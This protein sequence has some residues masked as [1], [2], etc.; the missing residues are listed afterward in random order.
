[1]KRIINVLLYGSLIALLLYVYNL[2]FLI[3]RDLRI[4]YLWLS[5][6]ILLLFTGFVFS[7]ISWKVALNLHNVKAGFKEAIYSQGIV[8]FTKYIPGRVW[9]ILGRAAILK[10]E[11]REL[12]RLSFI[13]FKEQLVYLCLGFFISIYPVIRTEKIQEYAWIIFILTTLLFLLLF[14]SSLQRLFEK[15]WNRIFKKPISLPKISIKEFA[16]LS[17]VIII[18]WFFWIAGFY[19]LLI[20]VTG[21]VPFYYAFAF[22]LSVVLGLI[23]IIFPGGIGVREGAITLFLIS[24]GISAD[25]AITISILARIWFLAGEFFAFF[26]ALYFRKKT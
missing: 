5:I 7:A 4:N 23:S 17:G 6:S 25:I 22:P 8:G 13:S 16:Q 21:F 2:D 15:V 3:F 12:K 19:F 11:D 1:M 10:N 9:T 26:L 24:N 18:W 14:S 20:S